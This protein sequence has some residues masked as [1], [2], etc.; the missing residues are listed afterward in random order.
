MQKPVEI[1]SSHFSQNWLI[2]TKPYIELLTC[3]GIEWP[4]IIRILLLI[5]CSN[6]KIW[7]WSI[8]WGRITVLPASKITHRVIC[9][10]VWVNNES[11]CLGPSF[12][13]AINNAMPKHCTCFI[14]ANVRW[15]WFLCWIHCFQPCQNIGR[16][17]CLCKLGPSNDNSTWCTN[18]LNTVELMWGEVCLIAPHPYWNGSTCLSWFEWP[19]PS[20]FKMKDEMAISEDGRM[21]GVRYLHLVVF[22]QES[23]RFTWDDPLVE[24]EMIVEI[25]WDE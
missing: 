11:A 25:L 9:I 16:W 13:A 21:V 12:P 3:L 10:V 24:L 22:G 19:M 5:I 17:L 1:S 18:S 15:P 14:N 4:F 8:C 20:C 2:S 23:I 7:S 6:D